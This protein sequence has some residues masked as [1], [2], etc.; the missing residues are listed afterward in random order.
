MTFEVRH[1]HTNVEAGMGGAAGT[2]AVGNI[3]L[4]SKGFMVRERFGYK[5][6]L[7]KEHQPGPQATSVENHMANF[8]EVVR[9]RR[10]ADLRADIEE[11]A[12]SCALI[13]LANISYRLGRTLNLDPATLTCVG[14]AEAN[15][16]F[17]R[18]YR[19]PYVVPKAV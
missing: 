4:G 19:A 12:I 6:F 16:M 11:G 3:F 18:N 15:A 2:S 9:T 5:T 10:M 7:G 1:W 14:D 17:T 13:H 8:I